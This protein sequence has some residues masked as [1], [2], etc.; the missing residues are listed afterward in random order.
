MVENNNTTSKNY[1]VAV[2][3]LLIIFSVAMG[4][5]AFLPLD[6]NPGASGVRFLSLAN[7]VAIAFVWVGLR[8]SE[9][10]TAASG[11]KILILLLPWALAVF[12][13]LRLNSAS[14]TVVSESASSASSFVRMTELYLFLIFLWIV[15]LPFP[16]LNHLRD[17]TAQK[18]RL[19]RSIRIW[20]TLVTAI[21]LLGIVFRLGATVQGT[22]QIF[23]ILKGALFLLYL[24]LIARVLL[25]LPFVVRSIPI[26]GR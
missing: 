21:V 17:L 14:V 9:L 15:I 5:W 2:S 20:S 8:R 24:F 13:A 16:D 23:P 22:S 11:N 19:L 4:A 1:R 12:V 7:A 3:I 6:Q 10:A 26:G 18:A 25:P